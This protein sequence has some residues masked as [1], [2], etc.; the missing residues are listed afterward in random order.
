MAKTI[1]SGAI[2]GVTPDM[3]AE[4]ESPNVRVL[5]YVVIFL[6]MLLVGCLVTVFAVIGYR[7]ANPKATAEQGKASQL[8]LTV[9]ANVQLGQVVMDGDRMALHLKGPVN[10]ELLVIDARRGRVISK[11]K[12]TKAAR[13]QGVKW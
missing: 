9:G 6:G 12:L 7:L 1:G 5:R 13:P 8:D 2:A 11:V 4:Q 3:Q 10:D